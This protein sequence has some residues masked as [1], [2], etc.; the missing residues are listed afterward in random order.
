MPLFRRK[1]KEHHRVVVEGLRTT[2]E[3]EPY[4]IALCE[5]GW[6]E[7]PRATSEEAF[8]DAHSHDSNVSE[9]LSYVVGEGG[10]G[11][12]CLFCAA[13]VGEHPIRLSASWTEEDGEEK[14]QWFA[15]HRE[16]LIQHASSDESFGGPLWG[17]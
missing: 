15:A 5:C 10:S 12:L 1:P 7:G 17:T 11:W 8:A 4:Y 13:V 2:A 14:G 16:C 6:V 9:E 3:A